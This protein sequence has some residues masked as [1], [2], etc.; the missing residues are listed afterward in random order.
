MATSF[1]LRGFIQHLSSNK[2]FMLC[3]VILTPFFSAV[4]ED[5]QPG[6][7]AAETYGSSLLP[8]KEKKLR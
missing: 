7:H 6:S 5:A 8:D 4:Q 1:E 2:C 3:C